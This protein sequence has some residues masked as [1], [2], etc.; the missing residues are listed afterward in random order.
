MQ[1]IYN[2]GQTSHGKYLWGANI[3]RGLVGVILGM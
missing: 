2:L 3:G 1:H